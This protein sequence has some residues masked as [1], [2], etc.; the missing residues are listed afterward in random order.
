M[1][2]THN[3]WLSVIVA[4]TFCLP[5]FAWN[6]SG[7][8]EDPYEINTASDVA[9]LVVAVNGGADQSGVYFLQTADIDLSTFGNFTPIGLPTAPFS[10]SY[11]GNGYAVIN[12]SINN[13]ANSTTNAYGFFGYVESATVENLSVS[14]SVEASATY[15]SS[16]C[17]AVGG[18]I[19]FAKNS[20]L[21]ALVNNCSVSAEMANASVESMQSYI[22]CGVGG[23]VGLAYHT[24]P[25]TLSSMENHG[26]ISFLGMNG[27]SCVS[28]VACVNLT[29]NA[30]N[31]SSVFS[32][33]DNYG[34]ISGSGIS[35]TLTSDAFL[36]GVCSAHYVG[37]GGS[38]GVFGV[39][40]CSNFGELEGEGT[41]QIS[42]VVS[43]SER[44]SEMKTLSA[45]NCTNYAD[46]SFSYG[47]S[48]AGFAISGVALNEGNT[49]DANVDNCVNFGNISAGGEGVGASYVCGVFYSRGGHTTG[50]IQTLSGNKN[51]GK[52][53]VTTKSPTSR[54]GGVVVCSGNSQTLDGCENYG[55]I[56]VEKTVSDTA[57]IGGVCS[58]FATS[59]SRDCY[60]RN[61]LNSAKIKFTASSGT[62]YAGGVVSLNSSFAFPN[63]YITNCYSYGSFESE[64]ETAIY[65]AIV[66]HAYS[67]GSRPY[68]IKN[69]YALVADGKSLVG[70][71]NT[72]T[73]MAI[74][75]CFALSP[76]GTASVIGSISGSY[77][78]TNNIG[79][80]SYEAVYSNPSIFSAYLKSDGFFPAEKSTNYYDLIMPMNKVL[81]PSQTASEKKLHNYTNVQGYKR[82]VKTNRK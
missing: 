5:L 34:K 6:G 75:D 51:Y 33:C 48:N 68:Y 39:N 79:S 31:N 69:C 46:V 41:L 22:K 82:Y 8:Y 62:H 57:L 78:I 27:A 11:D 77:L 43:A 15:S 59:S 32:K 63:T 9:D 7:T 17:L 36:S 47:D 61:C 21:A 74:R 24:M 67:Y 72:E 1:N 25:I 73:A 53:T 45:Q 16:L 37:S 26:S 3:K 29:Y 52:I 23:V 55:E 66:P 13:T 2:N 30:V 20:I 56:E 64:L 28:G 76:K 71:V 70:S 49:V 35:N 50:T 54:F 65:G 60:V 80:A 42:G 58:L 44:S 19:G 40:G 12:L 4:F 10:G 18:V 81:F 14:G 38:Y